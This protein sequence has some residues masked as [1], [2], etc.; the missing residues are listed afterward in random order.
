MGLYLGS[1]CGPREGGLLLTSEVPL[2]GRARYSSQLVEQGTALNHPVVEEGTAL[3]L[4]KT[5]QQKYA[6]VPRRARPYAS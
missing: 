2:Y 5:N 4:R 1:Y 3:S 6:V